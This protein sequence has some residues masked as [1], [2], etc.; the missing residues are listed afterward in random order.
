MGGNAPFL[1]MLVAVA[2]IALG[3][4]FATKGSSTPAVAE[5]QEE[6]PEVPSPPAE[7]TPDPF[8]SAPYGGATLACTNTVEGFSISYPEG[9]FTV[10]DPAE[11]ACSAF[12]PRPIE[13]GDFEA[14]VLAGPADVSYDEI[15]SELESPD[16]TIVSRADTTIAGRP[17]VAIEAFATEDPGSLGYVYVINVDGQGFFIQTSIENTNDYENAKVVVDQMAGTLTF[18]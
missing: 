11:E 2:A 10:T 7:L 17:A 1:L 6:E 3:V 4:G 8:P 13:A 9:W 5:R 16:V 12:A 14:P 15:L 18:P